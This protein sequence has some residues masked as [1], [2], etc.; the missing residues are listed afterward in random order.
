[1][2]LRHRPV[3]RADQ[4]QIGL[5]RRSVQFGLP[6]ERRKR[7]R[8]SATTDKVGSV[9]IGREAGDLVGIGER[10]HELIGADIERHDA[11]GRGGSAAA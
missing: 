9:R 6:V 10:D 1:M 3:A 8:L 5:E 2:P 11:A 7:A 4:H